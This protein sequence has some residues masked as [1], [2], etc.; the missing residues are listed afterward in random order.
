METFLEILKYTLPSLVVFAAAYFLLKEFLDDK[1]RS[2]LASKKLEAQ[3]I[4]L[5]LRLQA[6]ER[7][8]LFCDRVALPNLML[9]IQS[10]GMTVRDLHAA[11]LVSIRQEFEHNVAQQIYVSSTLWQ[12]ISLA[13]DETLSVVSRS[14]NGLEPT[15]D[16]EQLTDAL[17]AN[18]QT[19]GSPTPLEKAL[20]AIRTEAASMF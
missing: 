17:F 4:T 15:A 12:I 16:A 19:Q 18:L 5:P 10:P 9:R 8:A 1:Q 7:F 3:K 20:A 13:V 6:Y 14:A 11:L 2:N